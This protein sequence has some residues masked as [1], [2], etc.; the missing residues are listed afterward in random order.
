MLGHQQAQREL[1]TS[2]FKVPSVMNDSEYIFRCH[3]TIWLMNSSKQ[4]ICDNG[5]MSLKC[6]HAMH[7]HGKTHQRTCFYNDKQAQTQQWFIAIKYIA[8]KL[9]N[10]NFVGKM[11]NSGLTPVLHTAKW[12]ILFS[13]CCGLLSFSFTHILQGCFTASATIIWLSHCQLNNPEEYG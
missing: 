1:Q 10:H 3:R 4:G 5:P 11:I 9:I 8:C 2:L 13:L 6:H 12:C 7:F